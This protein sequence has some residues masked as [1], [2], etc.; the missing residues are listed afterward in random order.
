MASQ[1][2]ALGSSHDS[3]SV[4]LRTTAVFSFVA[5]VLGVMVMPGAR[6]RLGQ[7]GVEWLER[8]TSVAALATYVMAVFL[9]AQGSVAVFRKPKFPVLTALTAICSTV[10]TMLVAPG[11]TRSL[12]FGFAMGAT[13]AGVL[14]LGLACARTVQ[15]PATRV[16][17]SILG[18]FALDGALRGL[19]FALARTGTLDSAPRSQDFA[20]VLGSGHVVFGVLILLVVHVWLAARGGKGGRTASNV[21]LLSAVGICFWMASRQAGPA[22]SLLKHSL[23]SYEMPPLSTPVLVVASWRLVL[24]A[25]AGLACLLPWRRSAF[26]LPPLVLLVLG[27]ASLDMPLANVL[28]TTA[29]LWLCFAAED[30][31]TMWV[32][33]AAVGQ[34]S[35]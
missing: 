33:A 28:T 30:P 6:G 25:G 3:A 22:M 16:P 12:P 19:A 31:R 27:S 9:L 24:G 4:L 11:L 15:N 23:S 20:R 8:G 29:A 35:A 32:E 5:Y 2:P 34:R 10:A 18:G 7:A 17:G 1:A 26:V 21:G 13:L 14:A